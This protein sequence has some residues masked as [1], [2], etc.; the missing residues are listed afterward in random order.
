[1]ST[2]NRSG[3]RRC[4]AKVAASR[5]DNVNI[6][7]RSLLALT[8]FGVGLAAQPKPE[9]VV[10]VGHAGAPDQAAFA[11]GHLVTASWSNVA[12]IDLTSGLTVGHLPQG[13]LVEALEVNP[14]GDL[15]A[16]GTCGHAIQLWD[17]TSRRLQ[18]RLTL[19][20]ECAETLS[21]SPD[22]ALLATGVDA[23]CSN[24]G[25]MQVWDVRTGALTRE[26]AKGTAVR[27]VLF[28]RD[29]RWLAGIADRGKASVFEWPSGRLLV[30]LQGLEGEGAPDS[31]AVASPDG[32]YLAWLGIRDLQ[33]WEVKT[34]AEVALPAAKGM[35]STVDFLSDGRLAYVDDER[36]VFVT[37]PG[38]QMQEIPIDITR[39]K[40]QAAVRMIDSPTWLKIRRDGRLLAGQDNSRT[41]LWDVTTRGLRELTSPALPDHSTLQW[42]KSGFIAWA[43]YQSGVRLWN[44]KSGGLVNPGAAIDSAGAIALRHDGE[45]VIVADYASVQVLDLRRQ[46][47]V[48]SVDLSPTA[49]PGVAISPDGTRIA[50][51]SSDAL[52]LSDDT[53]RK[54][55]RLARLEKDASVEYVAFSPDG[56]WIAAGLEGPQPAVR[57][58]PIG[59]P[60]AAVTL[61]TNRV[62]YGP[63]PP[64]FNSDSRWLASFSKGNSLMLWATGSW[65]VD[66]SWTLPG[67]GR[68]LAFEPQGSRLAIAGDGEAAIWDASTARKLVTLTSPS[69]SEHRQIAWSPDG[70][71]VVTSADD[72]VLR[73]WTASDG[74]LIASLFTFVSGADW[75]LM[76]PDGQV[77]GTDRALASLVAWRTGDRVTLDKSITD[78]YRVRGLWRT[79]PTGAPRR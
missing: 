76:T 78:R 14:A 10:S 74:R 75:I 19:T 79:L 4:T 36:A 40:S 46:R 5:A 31:M 68:A 27:K 12:L 15:L 52:A 3:A 42:H 2:G 16:V 53:L 38:G 73:I 60:G 7:M 58:W 70:N 61:D 65:T 22:G 77:D 72:G 44:D 56:R 21:F 62:T 55:I 57:V 39:A 11:A 30:S 20:Q 48:G 29:G 35:V 24:G 13:S 18:R 51:T 1:M 37:L 71:R 26:L 59:G 66:K 8:L 32:Q 69:S 47:T 34:G 50:F 23:C 49:G 28:S 64:A 67:T 41:V 45:R 25:G 17:V 9:L 43:D 33:V 63:Q 6:P 54:P